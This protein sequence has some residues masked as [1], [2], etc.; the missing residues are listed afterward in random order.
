MT[1]HFSMPIDT[2]EADFRYDMGTKE[3]KKPAKP[4]IRAAG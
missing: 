1:G 3:I 2:E 4:F